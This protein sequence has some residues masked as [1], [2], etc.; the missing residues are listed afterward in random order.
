[1]SLKVQ[2][3][4][5][6]Q[7]ETI[8]AGL[9]VLATGA[10][11]T[12][13]FARAFKLGPEWRRAGDGLSLHPAAKVSALFPEPVG[14]FGVP[15][16]LGF[17]DPNDPAVRYEGVATPPEASG[18]TMPLDGRG[19]ARWMARHDRV[20][21]FGFMVRDTNRGKVRYPFGPGLPFIRYDLARGDLARMASASRLLARVFFAAGAESVL[22]PFNVDGNELDNPSGLDAPALS[23]PS[24]SRLYTMA[25]H[26]MGTC[27]M[28]RVVDEDLRLAP[29][30]HVC[31]GSVVPESLGVNPQMTIYAFGLR[32]AEHLLARGR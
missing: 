27:G 13:Y 1:V 25:F 14:S 11:A 23:R 6:G 26:P 15:Q 16:G 29:G 12:P 32:L 8:E 31:D 9:L 3:L 5:T 10:L 28:G 18:L 4:E 21:T 19:L 30:I 7:D 17:D 2:D 20:A 24:P 22:M